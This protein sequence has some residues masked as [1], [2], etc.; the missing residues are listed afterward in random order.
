MLSH[1]IPAGKLAEIAQGCGNFQQLAHAQY[2]AFY[3]TLKGKSDMVHMRKA[4][5]A[6]FDEQ[7]SDFIGALQE[8][9]HILGSFAGGFVLQ[10]FPRFPA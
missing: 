7:C 8:S 3:R 6:V 2:A 9:A 5:R 1:V 10:K 4:G